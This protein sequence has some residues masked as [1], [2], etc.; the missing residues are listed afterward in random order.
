MENKT[1][2]RTNVIDYALDATQLSLDYALYFIQLTQDAQPRFYQWL[3]RFN[4]LAVTPVK[5][6]GDYLV[7]FP[8]KTQLTKIEGL[9]FTPVQFNQTGQAITETGKRFYWTH[10]AQLLLNQMSNQPVVQPQANLTAQLFIS[11]SDWEHDDAF[12]EWKQRHALRVQFNWEGDL[13]L[14]VVTFTED[15][16]RKPGTALYYWDAQRNW[17]RR[18][19][20]HQEK[21]LYQMGNGTKEKN[22]VNFLSFK[23]LS[24]YEQSKVGVIDGLLKSLNQHNARYLK[25]SRQFRLATFPLLQDYRIKLQDKMIAW[26]RLANQVIYVYADSTQKF[27]QTLAQ[28]LVTMCRQSDQLAALNIR[29]TLSDKAQ[30]GLNIQVIRDARNNSDVTE[31]YEVGEPSQIIQHLTVENFGKLRGP[32]GNEEIKW[33]VPDNRDLA[34]DNAVIKIAQ[35]LAIKADL[36]KR[37]LASISR[38]LI[39]VTNQYQF[40]RFEYL[41]QQN[42]KATYPK[43]TVTRL[44]C[45]CDGRLTI[46]HTLVD[47]QQPDLINEPAQVCSEVAVELGKGVSYPSAWATIDCVIQHGDQRVMITQTPRQLMPLVAELGARVASGDPSH[48]LEKAAIRR[49]LQQLLELRLTKL[50]QESRQVD[51]LMESATDNQTLLSADDYVR[52]LMQIQKIMEDEFP[53]ALTINDCYQKLKEHGVAF[54]GKIGMAIN[55]DLE[56]EFGF[57]FHRTT[58]QAK[59]YSL[60][61]GFQKVGLLNIQGKFHYFVGSSQPLKEDFVRAIRLRELR[62]LQGDDQTILTIFPDLAAMMMVEFVRNGQCTV[63]PYVVKYLKEYWKREQR[64]AKST[65]KD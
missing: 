30:P 9:K 4:G 20:N 24:V 26:E 65:I 48:M 18:S 52:Q 11:L 57:A 27:T 32:R 10:V 23:E 40:F 16:E 54:T 63:T 56:C 64:L 51:L 36:R 35:E 21:R 2:I 8:R 62:V 1:V 5:R 25:P 53:I 12:H 44:T 33:Q 42:D 50:K 31:A 46:D 59:P 17:M 38:D 43:I 3:A 19:L 6:S 15:K 7:L 60:F 41:E 34:Q 58:R 55:R 47:L 14:T 29:V 13:Q 28:K 61:N 39:Q 22:L 49:A 37:R 45:D